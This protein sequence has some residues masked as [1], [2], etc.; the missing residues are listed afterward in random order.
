MFKTKYPAVA[1]AFGLYAGWKLGKNVNKED[2]WCQ[3]TRN[4]PDGF[5]FKLKS[6][7]GNLI[8]L[9][10]YDGCMVGLD[11]GF[12]GNVSSIAKALPAA[13]GIYTLRQALCIHYGTQGADGTRGGD[14]GRGGN[15]TGGFKE[16]GPVS[17]G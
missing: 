4:F 5:Y 14:G 10:F 3:E 9:S 8:K 12:L 11:R 13:A 15:A 16:K 6:T 7:E 1:H 2:V 17:R